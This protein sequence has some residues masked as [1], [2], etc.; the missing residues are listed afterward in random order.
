MSIS[1]EVVRKMPIS[2]KIVGKIYVFPKPGNNVLYKDIYRNKKIT[3]P[4]KSERECYPE[5]AQVPQSDYVSI[6]VGE[7]GLPSLLYIFL[8]GNTVRSLFPKG[9]FLCK[10]EINGYLRPKNDWREN[11]GNMMS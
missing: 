6:K 11:M 9:P 4:W 3:T 8:L 2:V 5:N 7:W 1:A 10:P